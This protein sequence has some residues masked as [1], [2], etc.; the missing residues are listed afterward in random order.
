MSCG[1]WST[2]PTFAL[3]Y[4]DAFSGVFLTYRIDPDFI[5][6]TLLLLSDVAAARGKP[7]PVISRAEPES[8]A[9]ASPPTPLDYPFNF[10]LTSATIPVALA[11]H[12]DAHHPHTQRDSSHHVF[13]ASPPTSHSNSHHTP[14]ATATRRYSQN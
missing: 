1:W 10:I 4:T 3:T 2:K 11:A 12:L 8:K 13:T 7:V 6:E 9:P 5:D 14:Q